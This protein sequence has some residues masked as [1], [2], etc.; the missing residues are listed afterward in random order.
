MSLAI[1]NTTENV[2]SIEGNGNIIISCIITGNN[3]KLT[4]I[5][6]GSGVLSLTG[7]NTFT[8]LTK[9]TAGTLRL[10]RLGGTTIPNTNNVTINGGT[11]QVS[12]DQTLN[13]LTLTSGTVIIDAGV[14]LTINGTITRTSGLIQGTATSNLVITGASGTIAF[15]QTTSGTTN[16]LKNLTISGSGTTTLGNALN[17]TG[18]SS[19]GVVTVGSGA[20]LAT[21]GFLTLKSDANGTACIGNSA[22]TVSG[23]VTV[24]RYVSGAG[25]RWRFLSSP[26][27]SATVNNWMSQ[28]YVTGP[29]DSVPANRV[30]GSTLGTLNTNGW[31]TSLANINFPSSTM[32]SNPSS[33]KTTSIRTYNESV[34]GNNTNLNAGWE[35]LSST[36]QA[37]I[38]G[39]GFRVFIRGAAN[40][41]GQLDGSV[42]SQSAV[43]LALTGTVNQ[44][45][46]TLNSGS[47]FP[48]T[49][50]TQGWNLIGNPYP[51]AYNIAA[52]YTG[53]SNSLGA[54][55]STLV[56]IYNP[57]A[58]TAGYA[59]YNA[60][61]GAA[62]GTGLSAGIIPSGGAFF[63]KANVGSPTFTFQ[64]AYKT[65]TTAPSGLHKTDVNDQ[66]EIKYSKD[67][68]ESDYL[69]VKM[70]N[71]ATL[72]YDA[73]DILKIRNDNL[74][75]AAYGEDTMQVSA[76]VIQ[77][78]V[79]ET[80]IKLNVEATLIGTYTF[81]F[82]N[83][84]NFQSNITVSLFDRYT[85]KTTDVRKNTKYTF[86]MGAGVNQWGKNRFELILNLEKT[87][88]DE[89]A[90]LNQTHML[91]YPNPATDVL[92]ISINNATFKNSDIVVYNI[93]GTEVLKTNMA[94]TSAQLNIETLSNG[95]YF[96]KVSNQNGFNKT[97]KFVK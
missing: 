20:I 46:I 63:I 89:F 24:E 5:G 31:H 40:N 68:V 34:S 7:A 25:R 33:V 49:N 2:V 94:A 43:T 76:S 9:V 96:V 28:F 57:T 39:Q 36:S 87:N 74:N 91:V 27:T 23:S 67:S 18:G 14:T 32:S 38:P 80:R 41:T 60:N 44:G 42:T 16:V 84:D 19:F 85:N 21:G 15:D 29:G 77:P 54:N 97:V 51:C 92:N 47:T 45:S 86:D 59:G 78:V 72:N 79:S 58:G 71:G 35:N 13:D 48:I 64:E 26:V 3:K 75:L 10:N 88:V 83:M 93:S 73:F 11:L 6:I 12:T 90:L 61:G 8:G 69:T 55:C 66:F 22:G 56:Y 70:Y 30:N 53:N 17:I 65:T 95:V 4:K 81:D 37:L 52:H 62:S 82:K 1:Q 50:A